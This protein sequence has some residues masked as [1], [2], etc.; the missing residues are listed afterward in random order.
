M[1]VFTQIFISFIVGIGIIY[2]FCEKE[3]IELID[4]I[5]S[6]GY[7]NRNKEKIA[8]SFGLRL[9]EERES[10]GLNKKELATI[11][12]V[13]LREQN[14]YEK[15]KIFMAQS[16]LINIQAVGIDT[17]YILTGKRSIS[18]NEK[19]QTWSAF[20]KCYHRVEDTL[21]KHKQSLS[22]KDKLTIALIIFENEQKAKVAINE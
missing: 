1:E 17:E 3:L 20:Y 6:K 19:E 10:R 5:A 16:Y 21:V 13:T 22:N 4:S 2:F 8:K 7:L 9:K 15:S 12:N 18:N 11:G 14:L